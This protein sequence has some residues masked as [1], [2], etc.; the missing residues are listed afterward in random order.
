MTLS[1]ETEAD[2]IILLGLAESGK[3]TIL[4]VV[5]E[6]YIPDKKAPYSATLDYTRKNISLFGKKLTVFDLGGQKAFLDRFIGELAEFI[7]SG[8]KILIFV[9]DI[10]EVNR[11]SLAKYYLDLALKRI[12][13]YSST[14]AVYV[15][16]HKVDLIDQKDQTRMNEFSKN[17]KTFLSTESDYPVTFFE[18]S[19]FDPAIFQVFKDLITP[20]TKGDST[21]SSIIDD[22]VKAN[23]DFVTMVQVF[24]QDGQALIEN[25]NFTYV[26]PNNTRQI[27]DKMSQ[28]IANSKEESAS[29]VFLEAK[30]HIFFVRFLEKN[31]VL[32]LSFSRSDLEAKKVGIPT[33]H[34]RV[35]LLTQQLNRLFS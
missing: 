6:G 23:A 19:V 35:L 33:M 26:S 13:Q 1:S 21:I 29:S 9:V 28:Y 2:K 17:I 25:G 8:V 27:L 22:F 12:K 7:F 31:H 18:T 34:S 14:A 5:S 3:T 10:V 30:D 11:L 32:L 24:T 15:F 20:L 16:L 4:K